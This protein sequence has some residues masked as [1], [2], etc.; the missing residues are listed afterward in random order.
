[1]MAG[2]RV[3]GVAPFEGWTIGSLLLVAHRLPEYSSLETRDVA[4][5]CN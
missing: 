3:D 5:A 2:R 1:M 4:D